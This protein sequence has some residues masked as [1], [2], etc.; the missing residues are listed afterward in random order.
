MRDFDSWFAQFRESIATYSY[1]IDFGKVV[2]NAKAHKAELHLLNSLIGSRT[3]EDEFRALVGRY[4]QVLAVV[5][6]LLA[7]REAEIFAADEEGGGWYRF[8][9]GLQSLDDSCTFMRKTGL[10]DL[11]ANH[12]VNNLYDYVLGVEA[13]LDSNGRKNRGGH[14]MEDL[15]EKY[16]RRANLTCYKE[17]YA[18]EV[19]R[20]FGVDLS[21]LTNTGKTEKRFDFVVKTAS[22]VY[23][24]EANFYGSNGSKLNET[25][26]SYKML[27]LE[28]RQI[29]NFKFV[30]FTDGCG[31]KGAR[32]NL[33][34]TFDILPTLY[35]IRDLESGVA[36][37]LFV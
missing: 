6:I 15:V 30:W 28:A 4:P 12:L 37:E 33:R 13:G 35:N 1:Y 32:Q 10:F 23:A 18:R 5:P 20:Q 11:I 25:A 34:E 21:S 27:A 3:V 31:W 9:G 8:D 19:S 17:M 29:P 7:K 22:C 24:I 14:L 36:T 26:R 2:A 16:L